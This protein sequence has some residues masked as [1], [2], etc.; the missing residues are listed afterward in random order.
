[1]INPD[2]EAGLSNNSSPVE[3]FNLFATSELLDMILEQTQ[4]Y[5]TSQSINNSNNKIDEITVEDIRKAF[6]IVLY[7]G[8]L[9]LPNRRM[10]WQNNTRVEIIA[11]TMGVNR[12]GKIMQLLHYNDNNLIP[13][14]NRKVTTNATRFS[15]LLITLG[16]SS[17]KL[18]P[19]KPM[20]LLMNKR[21]HSKEPVVSSVTSRRNQRNE[22]ISYGPLLVFLGT[23]IPSKLMGKGGKLVLQMDG[24]HL[25]SVAKADLLF[26]A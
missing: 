8:I 18:L 13:D 22:A 23:S 4:L 1:M 6:G 26:F 5:A 2:I 25:K 10:Y 16:K 15:H 9:K 7:M 21:Y 12:F 14:R 3:F 17:S 19:L 24:M 11:N 20:L